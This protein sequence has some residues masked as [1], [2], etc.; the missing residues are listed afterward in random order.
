MRPR[1]GVEAEIVRRFARDLPPGA[2]ATPGTR[3]W[4]AAARCIQLW[5]SST[6]AFP[7]SVR[8]F[9]SV[10]ARISR[11]TVRS[12]DQPYRTDPVPQP[13]RLTINGMLHFDGIS[14]IL[15]TVGA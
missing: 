3:F 4:P 10:K 6:H 12:L 14:T 2:P 8:E 13:V 11:T 5:R 9:L 1:P 15:E 7:R